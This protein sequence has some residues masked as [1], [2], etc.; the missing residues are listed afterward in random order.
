MK[1]RHGLTR[2]ASSLA[3]LY[4]ALPALGTV[5]AKYI[6]L[7]KQGV[8]AY[9]TKQWQAAEQKF[10]AALLEKQKTGKEDKELQVILA[11]LAATSHEEDKLPEAETYSKRCIELSEKIFGA[12]DPETA[13][14]Y[15]L[16]ATIEMSQNR[17]NDAEKLLV[18]STRILEKASSTYSFNYV[19]AMYTL[20]QC[21][22][23][24]KKFDAAIDVAQKKR[25]W[26]AKHSSRASTANV[27]EGADL[28]GILTL[29]GKAGK[30]HEIYNGL[31]KMS[32]NRASSANLDAFIRIKVAVTA[33]VSGDYGY[34]EN[35]LLEL[36]GRHQILVLRKPLST[37]DGSASRSGHDAGVT[38]G[39]KSKIKT[40]PLDKTLLSKQSA[41][42]KQLR[43]RAYLML[44]QISAA[45]D[46]SVKVKTYLTKVKESGQTLSEKGIPQPLLEQAIL[47]AKLGN[48]ELAMANFKLAML[49]NERIFGKGSS[50][51]LAVID[52]Y[53]AFLHDIKDSQN[54]QSLTSLRQQIVKGSVKKRSK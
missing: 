5:E 45:K 36:L 2:F 49:V 42:E 29:A 25:L 23:I 34:A 18:Q 14:Q 11:Y 1:V 50:K 20:E 46:D 31:Y 26:V 17:P 44:A 27:S 8:A 9:T 6:G 52:P 53:A 22:L 38:S 7:M 15:R 28:A 39:G 54:L 33:F 37:S 4:L 13:K 10:Q 12:N 43:A 47:Y 40:K 35:T 48:R 19:R 21:Y 30:A 24:E 16:L 51:L 41:A 3:A 32:L